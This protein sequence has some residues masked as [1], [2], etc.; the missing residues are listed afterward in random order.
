MKVKRVEPEED[1]EIKI[2]FLN[3]HNNKID[4]SYK[5]NGQKGGAL[6]HGFYPATQ[7]ICGDIHFDNE[8]WTNKKNTVW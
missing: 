6:T 8:N 7:Q 2:T 1:C 5:L 4:Y 3:D